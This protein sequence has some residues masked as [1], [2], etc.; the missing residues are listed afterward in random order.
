MDNLGNIYA[1]VIDIYDFNADDDRLLVLK[2]R[3]YQEKGL[4]ENYYYIVTV[5]IS[6]KEVQ[7][8]LHIK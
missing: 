6:K 3:G 5:K 2:G 8:Y 7:Q 1:L 4:I